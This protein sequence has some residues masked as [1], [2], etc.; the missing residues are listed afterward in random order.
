MISSNAKVCPNC[1]DVDPFY[2][3][4]IKKCVRRQILDVCQFLVW[5][6]YGDYISIF[7]SNH[8]ILTWS[9][10]EISIYVMVLFAFWGVT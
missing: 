5:P 7:G 9:D 1:G 4:D 6:F 8:G 3:D 10:N 2:F